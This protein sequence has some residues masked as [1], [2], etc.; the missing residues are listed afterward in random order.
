M[1]I[2]LAQLNYHIGNFENNV[3]KIITTARQAQSENADLVVFSELAISG[4]PPKDLLEIDD[5]IIKCENAIDAIADACYNIPIIIGTPMRNEYEKGKPLFNAAVFVYQSKKQFFK[6]TLL[7][8]YDI[9]DEYR[10]F[11]P[12]QNFEILNFNNKIIA[13]TICEDLWNISNPYLYNV[14]PL[15]ELVKFNPDLVIN[16]A[17]SPFDYT[18]AEKRN[19]ILRQNVL[20]YKLPIIY[21]NQVG[22]Q[23][24]LLFDGGSMAIADNGKIAKSLPFFEEKLDFVE[25]DLLKGSSIQDNQQFV[26]EKIELMHDALVMGIKDY[27]KKMGFKKAILGLSGGIDSAL[28]AVLAAEA[29]GGEN[30]FGLLMPSRFSSDHSVKDAL[31]LTKNLGCPQTTIAIEPMFTAFQ[32]SLK[33]SFKNTLFDVTEENLQARLR[34]VLL[35]AMSNKFGYILLN[36]SNKSECAVGYGTLYGDMCGGISVLGDLYKT[37]VFEMSRW[38]NRK[39]EIIPWNTINKPPSAELRPNQKDC[40]SLPEYD[41][42]DKI[43]FEHIENRKVLNEL[44]QMGFDKKIVS[45]VLHLVNINEYKRNQAAPILRVSPKS[46]GKG[47]NMPIVAKY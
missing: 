32:K 24:E 17:A 44:V 3:S 29:L 42:L 2:A 12:S 15:D 37:E 30:V 36:T 47:R 22:A 46:F 33:T 35:M 43:L 27:F 8:D 5:F 28:T 26:P 45:R 10:Y 41:I 11:E 34:A 23:T 1:K 7:P 14:N 19:E 18:Q 25:T 31:D 13:V 39:T 16:I 20:K 6:K 4:Y 9:F 40:D 21:V 38:I